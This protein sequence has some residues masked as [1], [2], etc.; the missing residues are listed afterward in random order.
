MPSIRKT[1]TASGAVA[2]QVVRYENR[3]VII[4][5]HV[6]SA[7][8]PDEVAALVESAEAWIVRETLQPALF[9]RP[10]RRTI[11]L[12]RARYVGVRHMFAYDTIS[13]I[14]IRMGFSALHT[15]LLLDLALMRLIEPSSKLRA[16]TLME[17]YFGL[18]YAERTVYRTLPKLHDRKVEAE[19]IAVAWA[20][21]GLSAD[22]AL[23]L[24][25]VT[26]LYFETFDADELRV[27]GFSKDNK[28]QQPQ[29]VVG[30]LVT[31]EG[32]P[33]G[34]EV[35]KGNTFEG[36]TMLPVLKAFAARHEVATP[37]V[38]ADAAMIS[39]ANVAELQMHRFS[40]IVGARLAN[41]SPTVIAMASAALARK[42]GATTRLST[43]HGDL[44]VSFSAKRY[45]KDKHEMEK[46]IAKAEALVGKGEPGKRAK[47][48]T[49]KDDAG[50][51]AIDDALIAKTKLLLGMKGYYTNIPQATLDDRAVVERYHDL[52]HVEAAF[53]MA[54]SD[55]ETRP[56]FHYK[57]DAIRAHMVVC[58]IALA[59][60]K[61]L[62]IATGVSLRRI[63]D[64]LW[65][66][67]EA[68]I[69]DTAV[70][71]EFIL[72]SELG[73]DVCA[74]LKKLGLSY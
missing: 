2:V 31:R 53:R 67:T 6:G 11:A 49:R 72:R 68:R 17:R 33:L 21:R 46:Q 56:I 60:G 63:V 50:A 62:E 65:S 36:K 58:F 61:Y 30:L 73:E 59:I 35:F 45:R 23:V 4:M 48:V 9:A 38:V 10:S 24:Y 7:H 26:T 3:K 74:I 37:T 42:D 28:S 66:V 54:K 13:A 5:K 70:A 71:E 14:A 27:P 20:K 25:D 52:W 47:F 32:F 55:I 19:T 15:P 22:L 43:D 51:Y 41:A 1:K 18:H 12:S 29:I 16:I 8:T 40:Y 34:Y 57:E 64:I 69:I 44:V 39:R